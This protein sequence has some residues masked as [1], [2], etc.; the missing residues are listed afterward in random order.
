[1]LRLG[2][3]C[4]LLVI[5]ALH[6][7]V[8]R[9]EGALAVPSVSW[10]VFLPEGVIHG[11][12][13][14][15]SPKGSVP[16]LGGG[17][18]GGHPL[19]VREDV[20][21]VLKLPPVRCLMGTYHGGVVL[22]TKPRSDVVACDRCYCLA[23][24]LV[25]AKLAIFADESLG[26]LGSHSVHLEGGEHLIGVADAPEEALIMRG[27][28]VALRKALYRSRIDDAKDFPPGGR[29]D[30]LGGVKAVVDLAEEALQHL[31]GEYSLG[32]GRVSRR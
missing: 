2:S 15:L 13:D 11:E 8:C 23:P 25:R 6:G 32:G 29:L 10:T 14:G 27:R 16:R 31:Q 18:G 20:F 17:G 5:E 7:G 9:L 3:L 22:G 26:H 1:M 19:E 12:D 21:I 30:L 4:Q 28:I 24:L